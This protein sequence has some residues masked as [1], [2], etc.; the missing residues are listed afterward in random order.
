MKYIH[1]KTSVDFIR[2][3]A[4][5]EQIRNV[6]QLY[7]S[8]SFYIQLKR[9]EKLQLKNFS[10][11]IKGPLYRVT[12][13]EPLSIGG[14]LAYGGRFNIGGSQS[15]SLIG[16]AP[17]SALYASTN[18]ECSVREYR[19]SRPLG[20]NDIQYKLVLSK[21][22]M[23]WDVEKA[24]E[25]LAFSKAEKIIHQG[26][27]FHAWNYCKVPMP[28]QI[29]GFWLKSIGGDGICFKS[30]QMPTARCIALFIR[31]TNHIKNVFSSIQ[32]IS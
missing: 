26:P 22:L 1:I 32:K 5:G 4:S 8:H 21:P 12:N 19:R 15:H 17:F 6:K 20:P 9:K 29:L 25:E 30:T 3:L 11:Y 16:I 31:N 14:S 23:L 28:S 10:T 27:L 13:R 2:Y 24:V 18:L 7:A